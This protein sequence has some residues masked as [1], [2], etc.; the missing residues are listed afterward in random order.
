MWK[1]FE[2]SYFPN[3]NSVYNFVEILSHF[4]QYSQIYVYIVL[5]TCTTHSFHTCSVDNLLIASVDFD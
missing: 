4:P 5:L 1:T 3:K 2:S